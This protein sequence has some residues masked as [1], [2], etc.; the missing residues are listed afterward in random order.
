MMKLVNKVHK[1]EYKII[2]IYIKRILISLLTFIIC[3]LC[4]P[5]LFEQ[6]QLTA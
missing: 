3:L 4:N 6:S 5:P 1:D 2:K